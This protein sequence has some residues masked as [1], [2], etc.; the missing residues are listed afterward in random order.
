[1]CPMSGVALASAR[2]RIARHTDRHTDLPIWRVTAN[3]EQLNQSVA[4]R[5]FA[6]TL[7]P[8]FG[9]TSLSLANASIRGALSSPVT[10]RSAAPSHVIR[11]VL[12]RG[13]KLAGLG[14]ST[15]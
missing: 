9:L 5:H 8:A 3:D 7:F 10:A 15:C 6:M 11:M 1:M 13:M 4:V 2:R 12:R 14:P